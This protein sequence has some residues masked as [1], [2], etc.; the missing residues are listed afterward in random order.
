VRARGAKEFSPLYPLMLSLGQSL[1]EGGANS[2]GKEG[3]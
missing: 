2:K 1:F 3:S